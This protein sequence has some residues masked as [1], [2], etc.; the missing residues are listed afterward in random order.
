MLVIN[1][2]LHDSFGC[3]QKVLFGTYTL[4][5]AFSLQK[6]KQALFSF[7]TYQHINIDIQPKYYGST[8]KT[9]VI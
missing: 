5:F 2:C 6:Q 1:F 8:L 7:N 9:L 4:I 3:A